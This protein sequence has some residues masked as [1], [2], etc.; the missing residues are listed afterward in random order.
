MTAGVF[1]EP[2]IEALHSLSERY[3]INN[4]RIP[5]QIIQIPTG[6]GKTTVIAFLPR[7]IPAS[8][9][10]VLVVVP[11]LPLVEQTAISIRRAFNRH[12]SMGERVIVESIQSFDL[13]VLL[14]AEAD[15]DIDHR[16]CVVNIHKLHLKNKDDGND[17]EKWPSISQSVDLIAIDEAHH[18]PATMWKSFL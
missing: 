17:E 7:C 3:A 9:C 12:P 8:K 14:T 5:P 13:L 11:T 1:W 18:V 2:Q 15:S 16:F 4:G 6:C 10:T